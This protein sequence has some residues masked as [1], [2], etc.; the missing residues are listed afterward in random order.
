[1]LV[2]DAVPGVI[3]SFPSIC[4]AAGEFIKD[5]SAFGE[6]PASVGALHEFRLQIYSNLENW[7]ILS[8]VSKDKVHCCHLYLN[9]LV[10][11]LWLLSKLSCVW[12]G[13]N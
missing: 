7:V 9:R 5:G 6:V 12:I 10:R 11:R 8:E 1:M 13:Y 4:I 2:I 3:F